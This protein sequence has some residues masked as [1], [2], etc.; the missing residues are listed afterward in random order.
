MKRLVIV[1][2]ITAACSFAIALKKQGERKRAPDFELADSNGLTVRLGDYAGKVVLLD[3][4]A[5]WCTPCKASVPWFNELQTKYADQGFTVL[6]VSMDESGWAAVK[7]F[8]EKMSVA[9]PVVLGTK[10]IAYL[11]GDVDALPLAFFIDRSGRVAAIHLGPAS[12]KD[13][14]KL[15]QTLLAQ[16]P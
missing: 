10:R 13:Y 8:L 5:T 16:R 2:L 11:Y 14:E 15:V 12:R 7:P 9:Y 3:F 6:G 4:W 1:L